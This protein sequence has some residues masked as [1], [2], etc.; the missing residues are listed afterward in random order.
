MLCHNLW[1][2]E[3]KD[4]LNQLL[5]MTLGGEWERLSNWTFFASFIWDCVTCVKVRELQFPIKGVVKE[6]INQVKERST[7]KV[8]DLD[9]LARSCQ[10]QDQFKKI[11]F[12]SKILEIRADVKTEPRSIKNGNWVKS[13]RRSSQVKAEISFQS[14]IKAG[15]RFVQRSGQ[16]EEEISHVI[17]KI[18][19]MSK[20]IWDWL[21]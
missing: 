1:E 15:M 18:M 11:S 3:V 16:V 13:K 5:S 19:Q 10:N 6:G 21:K 7:Q 8:A 9:D 17:S 14:K 4:I 2:K 20:L 12:R